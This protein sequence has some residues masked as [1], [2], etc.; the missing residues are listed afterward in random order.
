MRA[1]GCCR[2]TRVSKLVLRTR[3]QREPLIGANSR[4]C[5]A[6]V[7]LLLLGSPLTVRAINIVTVFNEAENE[8]PAFDLFNE[9]I[10]DLFD[11]A[12]SYYQ[13][14]FE[15]PGHTLTIN[16]WYEDLDD[17][18]IG[19]FNSVDVVD[20]RVIEG[21]IR[22]D[23]RLQTGG[24]LRNW[25][26]DSTPASDGEFE[27]EQIL[28]DDVGVNIGD[29]TGF[30]NVPDNLEVGYQGS[31][32]SGSAAH[33][34]YDMLSTILHEFGHA[35]GIRSGAT[36]ENADDD[37][38]LNPDF[39]MGA[40]LAAEVGF[41][42]G[43]P[44]LSHVK[45]SSMLMCGGCGSANRRRRPSHAD[46]FALATS[47]DYTSI[48]VPRREFYG[49]GVFDFDPSWSGGRAPDLNDD[50]Y[51]RSGDL[52]IMTDN[53]TVANLFISRSELATGTRTLNTQGTLFV[54]SPFSNV[55]GKLIIGVGGEA[56][57]EDV[58]IAKNGEIDLAGGVLNIDDD[59]SITEREL[60]CEN[61]GLLSGFGTVNVGDRFSNEGEIRPQGGVLSIHAD[62]F[63][64]DGTDSG[65]GTSYINAT[66]G[67]VAFVGTHLDAFDEQI[68]IGFAQLVTFSDA[69]TLGPDGELSIVDGGLINEADWTASGTI[70]IQ[71][72]VP[73]GIVGVG[74]EGAMTLTD[75]SHT[76][77]MGI[78]DFLGPAT[79]AG[80]VEVIT[81][82]ARFSGGGTIADPAMITIAPN[83]ALWLVFDETYLVENDAQFSGGGTLTVGELA[84][85]I[86]EHSAS[87]ATPMVNHGRLELGD[88]P[89]MLRIE[90][91]FEQESSGVAQFQIGGYVAGRQFD[92]L[93]A[94]GHVATLAGTLQ[95]ALLGDFVPQF[96]DVF[97][98]ISADSVVDKFAD[99]LGANIGGGM[100]LDVIYHADAVVL[101]VTT[102]VRGDY[103]FDGEVNAP[104]YNVW[105][106]NFNSKAE[107]AADGNAD[108][109]INAPDYN[110]WRDNFGA[111]AGPAVPEPATG[112]LFGAGLLVT[113]TRR[114]ALLRHLTR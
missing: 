20:D 8:T 49:G 27:M 4:W 114:S 5:S 7:L 47:S 48:D 80:Q 75:T 96:G 81:E 95:L 100:H 21:N 89:G 55:R 54:D 98:I 51:L 62:R 90:A 86:F 50:A 12:E 33:L 84:T 28:W 97:E 38:D 44:D 23:T 35:L 58:E 104:D 30:A 92:F 109:I 2:P 72:T 59:L 93:D 57:A 9:G 19:F 31:A 103:N 42:D 15:D 1:S 105:R 26:I 113:I 25:Y 43:E 112:V 73:L 29:W 91:D 74:G 82:A 3:R 64:L 40:S 76:T 18:Y 94:S 46:L 107:L 24:D 52:V 41:S 87:V 99:V 13:D 66:S 111:V 16:F 67:G 45:P 88:S 37:Y 68:D 65:L 78:V 102:G 11:Y 79:V 14:I 70:E 108:G 106:D 34:K 60:C 10:Q 53:D 110:V 85:V 56:N 71:H 63:D 101:Q 36:H 77:T 83:A 69:W 6:L 17:N 39:M 22:I 61:D 32:K